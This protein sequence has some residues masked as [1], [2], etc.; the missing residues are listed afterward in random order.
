[1]AENFD[2]VIVGARCAGASLAN[3]LAR[4]GL[5][6]AVVE[7]ATFPR[8]TLSSHVFE[9]DALAFLDRLGLSDRIRA[10]GAPLIDRAELRMEGFSAV[11][12]LPKH[13]GDI[14]GA[15]S[16]RRH[17]LDPIL[18][19]AAEEAGASVRMAT[20]AIGLS[21]KEGRVSGV[22][23]EHEGREAELRAPLVVGADGRSS[24]IAKLCEA[25]RYNVCPNERVAYW[26]YFEGAE[27]EPLPTF[28]FQRWS[29]RFVLGLPTDSGLFQVATWPE[30]SELE[31]FGGDHEALFADQVAKCPPLAEVVADATRV[32]KVR[33]AVKWEGYFRQASGAG[34]VLVG[35]AGHFKDPAP[36]RGIGDALLQ[37]DALAPA[38]ASGLDGSEAGIDAEMS[39]WGKWRDKE[40]AEHYWLANDLGKAGTVPTVLAEIVGRLHERGEI[41]RFLDVLN[42]RAMPSEVVTPPLLAGAVGRLL[43]K[44]SDRPAMLR[45]TGSLGLVQARRLWLNRFPAYSS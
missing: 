39:K 34:W 6:V 24:T 40:F 31:R 26:G 17:L 25:R 43:V 13:D 41:D 20:K 7:Q 23:V 5:D 14:G 44:G 42:H 9:A 8:D 36:G 22:R 28:R 37:A 4:R 19:E 30:K 15:A 32:G 21:T 10:T 3:L 1:V 45:E 18:A 29:D 38:I 35:D 12:S 16:V 11:V 27:P 33:G 2:V